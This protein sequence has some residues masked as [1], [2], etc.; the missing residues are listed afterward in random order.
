MRVELHEETVTADSGLDYTIRIFLD[1]DP[2][3][4]RKEYDNIGTM[5]CSHRSYILGDKQIDRAS[6]V[7]DAEERKESNDYTLPLYLL[8]HSGLSMNTGGFNDPWDSG[9]V[10]WISVSPEKMAEEWGEEWVALDDA[11]KAAKAEEVLRAE[12][13]E[14]DAY[15][16]GMI[17]RF[18]LEDSAGQEIASCGGF[19]EEADAIADAKASV[20]ATPPTPTHFSLSIGVGNAAF[21]NV[22]LKD[23]IAQMLEGALET[24]T[25]G[26]TGP[27]NGPLRDINGNTVGK[28]SLQ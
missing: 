26:P 13:K 14:Y 25:V 22:A 10:G 8:D 11:A 18:V 23:A 7:M 12:V 19:Y 16:T 28:W 24:M 5:V 4:P 3:N 15:L 6:F 17:Y 9:Q 21:A 20:P 27:V 2:I 1:D